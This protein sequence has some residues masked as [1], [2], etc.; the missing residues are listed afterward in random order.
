MAKESRKEEDG[1]ESAAVPNAGGNGLKDDDER[2]AKETGGSIRVLDRAMS[3]LGYMAESRRQVGITE[4]ADAVGLSKATVHRIL[5]TLKEYSVVL[6]DDSGRY[7]MGPSVL[8]WADAYRQRAG[9]AEISRPLLR[10]LWEESHETVHLFIFEGGEAYYLD[11]LDSPH[12][13]GMRS[14]I[15][16]KRDLYSTSGGR[17]ILA[18]LP[19]AEVDAYL[20]RTELLPRTEN[21]VTE[22]AELKKLL[23]AGRERGF[24]EEVE[25]NEEGIRCVGAAIL[26]LRGCPVG[27]V[28]ISAPAYRFSDSQSLALG[29]KI[30]ETALAISRELGYRG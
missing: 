14:R 7:Q 30:R 15:G 11:K 22:K 26:D 23:A 21:T 20:D 8:F 5:S 17:A 29:A 24:C 13:V 16:A 27:A 4:I 6:K 3:V 19:E 1:F 9:L 28:S 18:A 10:R 2:N 12:P 25:E